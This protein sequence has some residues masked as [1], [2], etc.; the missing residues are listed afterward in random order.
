VRE[1]ERKRKR[2]RERERERETGAVYMA[3]MR[4]QIANPATEPASVSIRQHTSAYV[5]IRQQTR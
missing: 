3:V 5:S 1:K 2:E 4:E